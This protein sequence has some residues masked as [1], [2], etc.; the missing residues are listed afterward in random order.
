MINDITNEHRRN[1]SITNM[2]NKLHNAEVPIKDWKFELRASGIPIC[3]WHACLSQ[4]Y[5]KIPEERPNESRGFK[6]EFY[7][8]VGTVVHTVY[9]RWLGRLGFLFGDYQCLE[10]KVMVKNH[11]GWPKSCPTE[12]CKINK[13]EYVEIKL[14]DTIKDTDLKSAHCD[15]LIQFPWMEENHYYLVDFKT[16]SLATLPDPKT[17]LTS[18]YHKKYLTQTGFYHYLL[19]E[20]GFKIDGTLF[21]FVPRDNPMKASIIH[22]NQAKMAEKMYHTI[23]EEYR[24]AKEAA[25]TADFSDIGKACQDAFEK[26]DC[27]FHDICFSNSGKKILEKLITKTHGRLPILPE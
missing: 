7:V 18:A 25:L 4:I 11:L 6:F 16:C 15:G 26:P 10:C 23:M 12:N 17:R 21:W 3:Q 20:K 5:E 13:W 1:T 2:L 9:Q 19:E 24:Q 27:P 8:E 14:H 22:Y